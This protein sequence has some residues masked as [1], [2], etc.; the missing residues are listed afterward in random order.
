VGI[1]HDVVYLS[2]HEWVSR[3]YYDLCRVGCVVAVGP[4]V[5]LRC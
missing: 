4:G 2:M 5:I 1:E 3:V